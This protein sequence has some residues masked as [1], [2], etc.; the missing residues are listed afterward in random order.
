MA[1]E[2]KSADKKAESA[3]KENSN[4]NNDQ[5]E[6]SNSEVE[7]LKMIT[8]LNTKIDSVEGAVV[9]LAGKFDTTKVENSQDGEGKVKQKI[10]KAI[11]KNFKFST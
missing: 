5:Q 6:S 1:E 10:E 9:S 2:K 4:S 8:L 7:L 3:G 11:E